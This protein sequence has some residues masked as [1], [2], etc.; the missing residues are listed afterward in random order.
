MTLTLGLVTDIHFGPQASFQGKLRKL[1]HEGPRLLTE[2]VRSLREE[3]RPD[4]L[5]NLGDDIEDEARE[6]DL[7]RY[8]DCQW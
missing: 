6:I 5:I 4:L 3:V 8:E 7:A 1:S 2:V